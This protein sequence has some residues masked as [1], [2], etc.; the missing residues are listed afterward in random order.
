MLA[1]QTTGFITCILSVTRAINLWKPFYVI[2]RTI[3]YVVILLF[4]LIMFVLVTLSYLLDEAGKISIKMVFLITLAIIYVLVI[5]IN[6]LSIT[7]LLE[8]R[9]ATV[10]V[11]ILSVVYCFFNTGFLVY[12]ARISFLRQETSKSS[13]WFHQVNVFVLLPLN[14]ACKVRLAK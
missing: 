13:P 4:V 2:H 10:T 8:I 11:A 7:K 5:S 1:S 3:V 9:K 12:L 6:S 14:S